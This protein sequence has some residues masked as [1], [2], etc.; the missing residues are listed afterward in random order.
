MYKNFGVL[1][2]LIMSLNSIA[3]EF[4]KPHSVPVV[5]LPHA[6]VFHAL[7]ASDDDEIATAQAI[8]LRWFTEMYK[9]KTAEDLGV[10]NI[11]EFLKMSAAHEL[12][13]LN[14]RSRPT[15]FGAALVSC[16]S[17]D[18]GYFSWDQHEAPAPADPGTLYLR[19][20]AFKQGFTGKGIERALIALMAT[21]FKPQWIHV[22]MRPSNTYMIEQCQA[23]GFE[24]SDYVPQD[25]P[26]MTSTFYRAFKLR[27]ANAIN[28]QPS[29][30]KVAQEL[31]DSGDSESSCGNSFAVDDDN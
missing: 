13:L 22:R 5:G 21:V 28:S 20:L 24:P 31:P 15:R 8:Y 27:V 9:G 26:G 3:G 12:D 18:V 30:R 29:P 19:T 4:F 1:V 7:H 25:R 14:D 17:D 10:D 16:G 23:S 11:Q 2:F 6:V